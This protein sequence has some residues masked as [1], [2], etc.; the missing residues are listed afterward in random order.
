MRGCLRYWVGCWE[1]RGDV[2]GCEGVGSW[3]A[4]EEMEG[5]GEGMRIKVAGRESGKRL[6]RGYNRM[7]NGWKGGWMIGGGWERI[8]DGGGKGG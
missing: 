4:G 1:Q 5:D 3:G 6:E 8:V 2:L 7:G